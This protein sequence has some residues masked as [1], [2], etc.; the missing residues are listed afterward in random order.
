MRYRSIVLA[1]S[2]VLFGNLYACRKAEVAPVTDSSLSA[3]AIEQDANNP[4]HLI[5]LH[6]EQSEGERVYYDKCIWCHADATPAGP[7]NRTNLTPQ[8]PLLNDGNVMNSVNDGFIRNIVTLGGSALGKS[9]M[10]PPW[11]N[12]LS[13]EEIRDVTAYIRAVADPP[14]HPSANPGSDYGVK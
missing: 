14:Y 2:L 6:Y 8:P 7:S 10:M 13:E 5:A 1:L 4:Q 3:Y 11:G 12:T 9:P